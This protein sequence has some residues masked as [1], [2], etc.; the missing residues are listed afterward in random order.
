MH[1]AYYNF[2]MILTIS[3]PSP[4]ITHLLAFQ[5]HMDGVP[6]EV[7]RESLCSAA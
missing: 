2:Y 7:R 3:R 1:R 4:Y 6:C 5:I